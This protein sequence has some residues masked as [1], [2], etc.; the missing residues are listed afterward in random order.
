MA[1]MVLSADL[2][3]AHTYR[4]PRER[5]RGDPA[6]GADRTGGRVPDLGARGLGRRDARRGGPRPLPRA[7]ALQGHRA[8]RG[9]RHRRRRRGRRRPH[10][11]LH[12]LRH[13]LLPRHPARLGGR[14]RARRAG[15]CRAPLDLRPRG[16]RARDRGGARGDPPL[17]RRPAPR[18][19]RRRLRGD[20]P[21]PSLW[22]ADP[23]QR[24]ERGLHHAREAARL[25]LALV[26][27][28]QPGGGGSRR[29]RGR[30]A[31]RPHRRGVRRR[32]ALPP[33]AAPRARARP[34]GHARRP[35]AP[36]LRTRHPRP[37]LAQRA[38]WLTPTLPC[39]ICWPS[40]SARATARA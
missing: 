12:H 26:R 9:G 37:L 1:S 24:G 6:R 32:Q 10:Q 27:A 36:P 25:L 17:R 33:A 23:G 7:H 3:G 34:G 11:R 38:A 20:L 8:P 35:A 22:R 39:S 21:D 18:A 2:G 28:G 30:G 14:R 31:S 13:H 4:D 40:Y 15:R 19:V 16:G 5:P 29:L